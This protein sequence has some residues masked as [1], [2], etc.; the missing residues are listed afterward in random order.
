[1]ITLHRHFSA[2]HTYP[3]SGRVCNFNRL[4]KSARRK[5][6]E[7]EDKGESRGDASTDA[8][9]FRLVK[10]NIKAGL[11]ADDDPRGVFVGFAR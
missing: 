1:M 7:G 5:T 9:G 6:Y 8:Y 10:T 4:P 2:L 3:D 11:V